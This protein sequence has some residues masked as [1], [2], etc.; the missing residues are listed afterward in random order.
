M[1]I[2]L[3]VRTSLVLH[4]GETYRVGS[5]QEGPV[6]PEVGNDHL[7]ISLPL[8]HSQTLCCRTICGGC[9]PKPIVR[10]RQR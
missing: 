9:P 10:S 6:I 3:D 4:S 5:L 8:I 2:G 7:V 1:D